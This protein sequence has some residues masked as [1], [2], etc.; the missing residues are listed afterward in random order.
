MKW[1]KWIVAVVIAPVAV[2]GDAIYPREGIAAMPEID[3]CVVLDPSESAPE[4]AHSASK[5]LELRRYRNLVSVA[6]HANGVDD[7]LVHAVIFAESSYDPDAISPSGA[8]GLMQLMPETAKRYGVRDI[9]DPAQN[10]QGGT[11]HLKELL[12]LFEGDVELALAAY[13]AGPGAVLRAGH[14]IP[15]YPQTAAYVPK[16][17]GY[18]KRFQSN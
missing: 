1:A 17:M 11:K 10:I 5:S 14:R 13:N 7:A 8:S 4:P 15:P 18:Y 9:F 3:A 2:C 16:V 6:S 12:E